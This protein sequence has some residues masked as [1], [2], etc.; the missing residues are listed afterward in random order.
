[1]SLLKAAASSRAKAGYAQKRS[2]G[3]PAVPPNAR[4][5]RIKRRMASAEEIMWRDMV[6]EGIPAEEARAA[7]A[8]NA[9][10]GRSLKGWIAY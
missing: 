6:R 9:A 7:I 2:M 8:A 1:M 3:K 4:A 10:K 5:G